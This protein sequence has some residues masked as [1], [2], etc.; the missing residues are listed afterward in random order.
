MCCVQTGLRAAAV[1]TFD[2]IL[3]SSITSAAPVT[4]PLNYQ[5][6]ADEYSVILWYIK[7]VMA[8]MFE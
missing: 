8:V 2:F 5:E 6:F 3:Y 7:D 4:F 1:Y